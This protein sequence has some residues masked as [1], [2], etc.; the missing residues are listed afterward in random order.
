MNSKLKKSIIV[1]LV[2]ILAY[3]LVKMAMLKVGE[4]LFKTEVINAVEV[5][6]KTD[7]NELGIRNDVYDVIQKEYVEKMNL[8]EDEKILIYNIAYIMQKKTE[9]FTNEDQV[10]RYWVLYERIANCSYSKKNILF[11]RFMDFHGEYRKTF[12]N[13]KERTLANR[14]AERITQKRYLDIQKKIKENQD[15]SV[16]DSL[17]KEQGL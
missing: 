4:Y 10:V 1:I 15:C 6:G 17:I 14:F 7:N 3:V 2:L 9:D 11:D 8:K 5:A 13:T 12:R 16:F